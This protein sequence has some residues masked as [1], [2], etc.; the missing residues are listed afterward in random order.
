VNYWG[1]TT[2]VVVF[3]H[4]RLSMCP[5]GFGRVLPPRSIWRGP[6]V[7]RSAAGAREAATEHHTEVR[8]M[9]PQLM[10]GVDEIATETR[11]CEGWTYAVMPPSCIEAIDADVSSCI[12]KDFHGKTFKPP[13]ASEY[14]ELLASARQ[15]IENSGCGLLSFTLLD[16]S[17]KDQFVSFAERLVSNA[18]MTAGISDPE[19]L[20]LAQHLFPGLLTLQRLTAHLTASTIEIEIDS[21]SVSQ[22]LG[23]S[24]VT[25]RGRALPTARLLEFAYEGHRKRQ[26][27]TSPRLRRQGLRALDDAKSRCIQVADVFGNFALAYIFVHLGLRTRGRVAKASVLSAVFGDILDASSLSKD[28]TL[29][30][31]SD[32]ALTQPGGLTLGIGS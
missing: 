22:R 26:F 2:P 24:A 31:G 18:M 7:A 12:V 10:A 8:G 13:Q 19:A 11:V 14:Q 1:H 20:S 21:D 3:A 5:A 17:W 28:V 15:H 32:L 29:A 25:V 4:Y 23:T 9:T 6:E 30:G 16:T 27:P